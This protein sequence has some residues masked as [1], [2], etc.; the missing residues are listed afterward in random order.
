MNRASVAKY[1][2]GADYRADPG[3]AIIGSLFAGAIYA[4]VVTGIV[5]FLL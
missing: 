5:G 1:G 3:G 4:A 2:S